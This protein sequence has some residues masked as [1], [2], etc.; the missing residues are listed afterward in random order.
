MRLR[1]EVSPKVV[2]PTNSMNGLPEMSSR[3]INNLVWGSTVNALQVGRKL[4]DRASRLD[5]TAHEIGRVVPHKQLF[6]HLPGVRHEDFKS[7]EG[8]AAQYW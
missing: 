7:Q 8:T 6:R 1:A 3:L 2:F 4:L 5:G